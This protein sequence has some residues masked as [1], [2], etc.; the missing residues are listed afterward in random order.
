[1]SEHL[2][3]H[4]AETFVTHLAGL[5]EVALLSVALQYQRRTERITEQVLEW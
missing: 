3:C 2:P 5:S 1:V 4:R